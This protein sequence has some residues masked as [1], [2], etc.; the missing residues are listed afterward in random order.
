M[1]GLDVR[2]VTSA[3]KTIQT[4]VAGR[5]QPNP[6][7]ADFKAGDNNAEDPQSVGIQSRLESFA[8]FIWG[9]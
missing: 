8:R 7:C 2:V 1:T 6:Y 3:G 4:P 9:M 5:R